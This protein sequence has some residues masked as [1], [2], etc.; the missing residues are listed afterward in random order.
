MRWKL[1]QLAVFSAFLFANVHFQMGL[2]GIAA[3]VVA[4]ML[5]WYSSYIAA[6]LGWRLGYIA[7][8]PYPIDLVY[9]PAQRKAL[10]SRPSN[11]GP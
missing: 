3:P 6:R 1:F 11:A 5:A 4:G 7:E 8:K 9:R 10:Q 2:T